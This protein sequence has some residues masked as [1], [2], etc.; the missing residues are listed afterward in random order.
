LKP[1]KGLL[2]TVLLL[3]I[4]AGSRAQK[5]YTL[6]SKKTGKL[7]KSFIASLPPALKALAAFYSAMGGTDC[8]DQQCE[9]TTAL[10]LGMQGSPEQK[11][12]IRK[13]FPGDNAAKL[14]V[15]QDCYLPPSTS[16]SFSNFKWLSFTVNGETVEVNYQLAVIDH[17]NTRIIN[18]PDIYSF[19]SEVFKN[20]KR[21]LYAWTDKGK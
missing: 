16:V 3:F 11:E 4:F 12:L 17:G 9:L 21:V 18:G 1:I 7:N 8:L 15:G 19:N 10:G 20:K 6:I 13:Y 2:I 14:V 5:S